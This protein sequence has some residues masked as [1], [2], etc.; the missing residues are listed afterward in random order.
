MANKSVLEGMTSQYAK[1]K[2]KAYAAANAEGVRKQTTTLNTN[3]QKQPRPATTT[4]NTTKKTFLCG[5]DDGCKRKGKNNF[6]LS[7]AVETTYPHQAVQEST[8]ISNRV[9]ETLV[10]MT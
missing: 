10:G 3:K 9:E 2:F 6:T 1:D 5:T 4:K 8:G 7:P